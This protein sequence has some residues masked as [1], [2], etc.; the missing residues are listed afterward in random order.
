MAVLGLGITPNDDICV[1]VY[2]PSKKE[3]IKTF[4]T[5][6]KTSAYLGIP[7]STIKKACED[8]KRRYSV[9]L[10]IE[11]AIRIKRKGSV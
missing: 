9:N 2:D 4:D 10:D 1:A 3:L 6:K 8:R 11:V 7:Q 5:I